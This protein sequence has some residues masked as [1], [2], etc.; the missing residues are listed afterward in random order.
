MN[1]STMC[2]ATLRSWDL[3]SVP[4]AVGIAAMVISM[5]MELIIKSS[6]QTQSESSYSMLQ[7]VFGEEKA[8]SVRDMMVEYLKRHRMYIS[9]NQRLLV[10]IRRLEAMLSIQLTSLK[11]SLLYDNQMS[12]RG[13]KIWVNGAAFHVQMLIHEA[14]L[15]VQAIEHASHYVEPIEAA[16]DEYLQDLGALLEKYKTYKISK[17]ELK[18]EKETF[19][20]ISHAPYI[21]GEPICGI[22]ELN[23]IVRNTEIANCEMHHEHESKR[24]CDGCDM[25]KAFINH[26]FSKYEPI[27]N[28]RNYFSD[29]KNNINSLINQH[30]SFTVPSSTYKIHFIN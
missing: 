3:T 4:N 14:G 11:D 27:L 29:L 19:C 2:Q 13:F 21:K 1:S 24:I 20:T 6:T 12:S 17:T 28:L 9:D 26:V 25:T 5:V 8:S 7:R 16:I 10:E 22:R 23:C 30:D 18:A 15:R